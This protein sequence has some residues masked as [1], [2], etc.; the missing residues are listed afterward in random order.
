MS[1]I[2]STDSALLVIDVQTGLF[3]HNIP[4]YRADWLLDNI[5][6]LVDRAH[7]AGVPVVYIQ[8]AND[9][10]LVEG[11]AE[12]QLHPRLQP[13][14]QDLMIR[15]RHGNAFQSTALGPELSARRVRTVVVVGL[16]T[17]GCVKATCL[18]AQALGYRVVLVGDGHS[19]YHRQA[20][21]LIE[22]LNQKLSEVGAEVR[23]AQGIQF[24]G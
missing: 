14:G 1:T 15:K 10:F 8:H 9:R 24:G 11:S 6:M 16:V 7:Q 12:W 21:R 22:E 3:Q 20:A 18:G 4:V 5:T 13:V 23:P 17:H 19:S 2:A